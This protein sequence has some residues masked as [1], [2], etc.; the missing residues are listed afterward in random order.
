MF[1]TTVLVEEEIEVK[2]LT[3]LDLREAIQQSCPDLS[4]VAAM[5]AVETVIGLFKSAIF[6]RN[7]VLLP[8]LGKIQSKIKVA[9]PGRNPKTGE[10]HE[11]AA[12]HSITIS[13]SG[14]NTATFGKTAL[15]AVL[16]KDH[17]YCKWDATAIAACF[18]N[19]VAAVTDGQHRVELR[20]L[21]T[22]YPRMLAGGRTSRNPKTGESV[23]TTERIKVA[24]KCSPSL[25]KAMDRHYGV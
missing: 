23:I 5:Q 11:V 8:M 14:F 19:A 4:N 3:K 22:F 25:R 15:V 1:I 24:F 17:G 13:T 6:N 20:G 16:V 7:K 12:R 21:G 18:Y 2:T 9:R 10:T